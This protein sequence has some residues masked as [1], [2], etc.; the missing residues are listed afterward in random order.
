MRILIIAAMTACLSGAAWAGV[1]Q[2]PVRTFACESYGG[3]AID[4]EALSASI[5][6]ALDG[7]LG[8]LERADLDEATLA[9]IEAEIEAA[10]ADVETDLAPYEGR[11][12]LSE[13]EEEA[14][15]ARVESAIERAEAAIERAVERIEDADDRHHGGK[16]NVR[17]PR[18]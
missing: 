6:A 13:A 14:L 4:S 2:A 7:A 17:R 12:S 5:E 11:R 1:E 9:H 15:E 8:A 10:M 18:Y 3:D 16:G